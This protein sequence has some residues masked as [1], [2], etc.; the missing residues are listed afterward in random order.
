[1]Q[2]AANQIMRS[3]RR[4]GPLLTMLV[5]M[6][7]PVA[8][9][10][11]E[12]IVVTATREPR[13]SLEIPAAIDSVPGAALREDQ[14]RVNLSEVLGRVPG[15]VISNRQ[16]YAQDLQIS[17]RG[18][19]SR[20]SFGTRGIRII[21]DGIPATSPDG[22][23]QSSSIDLDSAERIEVLRGPFSV[24]YGNSS[25][26][27]IQV[28]SADGRGPPTLDASVSAGSF[29][30][31]RESLQFAGDQ[32]GLSY[33][34]NVSRFATDGYREHSSAVRELTNVKLGTELGSG[35]LGIVLGALEQANTQDPLGLTRR[36]FE[37]DPR[38]A[39]PSATL[40]NTRK[41]IRQ[42]Q[43]GATYDWGL[44]SGGALTSRLYLGTRHVTQYLGQQGSGALS[45]G[46]VVDLDRDFGGAGLRWAQ[47]VGSGERPV[48]I[49]VGIEYDEQDEVRRGFVNN[50]GQLGALRRDEDDTVANSD[51]YTQLD[52]PL[53]SAWSLSGGLRYSHVHFKS[54]D[55]YIIAGN[56]DDSGQ[57]TYV[58]TLPVAGLMY[59]AT[60]TLRFY[61]NAGKGFETPTFAE[62]AYRPGGATGLN[63]AL[64]PARSNHYEIGVK[65]KFSGGELAAAIFDIN[66]RDEIVTNTS[67]NGRT[68]FKNASRTERKGFELSAQKQFGTIELRTALTILDAR[69]RDGFT[70]GTPPQTILA[71]RKLPGVPHSTMFAEAVWRPGLIGMHLA[72]E[73]KYAS[74]I[75][76]NDANSDAAAGG[77][78][79]NLR[80]GWQQEFGGVRLRE[81][82]RVDNVT[83][84]RYAGSVIVAESQGRFFEPAPGRN[85]LAGLDVSIPF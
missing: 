63:L 37:A 24:L 8:A 57:A 49:T 45:S 78:V 53:T 30:T 22:Q 6:T 2:T 19:G 11:L 72:A 20:A 7:A 13:N 85:Y 38:Q 17:S 77:T 33:R 10:Q 18:F 1:M 43:A 84:R 52:W 9:Q 25:G 39:D 27:V 28:F 44:P 76:V 79:A 62:L 35:H 41:T 47:S 64:R 70:S 71:G 69:F 61:A 80:A 54:K 65:S 75:Y 42:N 66:S 81:F 29:G 16:N 4:S 51:A 14:M 21:A 59:R 15:L 40:F 3:K 58:R 68:D 60:E 56:P 31:H 48:R 34:G 73:V 5:C 67:L 74:R 36:Q 26:G 83:N 46:G 12:A 23:G 55:H 32:Q 82:V 50:A